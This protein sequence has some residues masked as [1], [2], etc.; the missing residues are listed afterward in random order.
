VPHLCELYP[1]FALQLRKKDRE[2]SIRVKYSSAESSVLEKHDSVF[3]LQ[4]AIFILF[5]AS[6]DVHCDTLYTRLAQLAALTQHVAH[7]KI[8]CFL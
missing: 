8:L 7:N 5:S 1:P 6:S 3:L 4:Y 2:T